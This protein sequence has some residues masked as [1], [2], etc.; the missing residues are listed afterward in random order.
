MAKRVVLG[1][2]VVELY[3]NL[4]AIVVGHHSGWSN[5]LQKKV[6]SERQ[7]ANALGEMLLGKVGK[8]LSIIVQ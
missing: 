4:M 3:L 7:N 6:T 5:A 8:D 1:E 2:L